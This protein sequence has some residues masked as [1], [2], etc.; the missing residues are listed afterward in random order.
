[1]SA[2]LPS[3]R[4]LRF[5]QVTGLIA[6]AGGTTPAPGGDF[7]GSKYSYQ[8]IS[9]SIDGGQGNSTIWRLDGGDNTNYTANINMPLPF[10]D[11]LNQ[12]SVESSVLGAQDGINSGGKVNAVTRSGT[13]SY[14]GNAFEFLRN[15]YINARNFFSAVPD[16]LHQNQF[17]GTFGGP[18][19]R[20]KLFA[21]AGYQRLQA[22][23]SSSPTAVRLPTAANLLGDFSVTDP[24]KGTSNNC[25]STG[26]N[27]LDPLTGNPIPGN[28]YATPPTYNASALAILKD[29]TR[30]P[31]GSACGTYTYT[32]PTR[33]TDN[34]FVTRVDWNINAKHNFYGRYFIDGYQ[35]PGVY[36]QNNLLFTTQA[37]NLERV[38]S[39]TLG[40]NW[41]ISSK[42]GQLRAHHRVAHPQ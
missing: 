33:T 31:R 16:S 8:T 12:F 13:N 17:G 40:E 32:I 26:V 3:F 34:Q 1:M 27:L 22:S 21:F 19:R 2:R 4:Q 28:K 41:A 9:V 18:I 25:S 11:A 38:Q 24:V 14:H 37:G 15:N 39:L 6:L 29:T 36:N 23:Q 35:Q 5:A 42:H 7:T 10:P 30:R 20:D